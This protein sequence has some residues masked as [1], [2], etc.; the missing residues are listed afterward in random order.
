[1]EA[2]NAVLTKKSGVI[3]YKVF[4][5]R[6]L[7]RLINFFTSR[8]EDLGQENAYLVIEV[9]FEDDSSNKGSDIS[10]LDETKSMKSISFLL[11]GFD[12][13]KKIFM[14]IGEYSRYSVESYDKDWVNA[15]KVEID[16]ILSATQD[17]NYW[18]SSSKWQPIIGSLIG[19]TIGI[20]LYITFFD[21]L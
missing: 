11:G 6:E 8:K 4:T 1:M 13:D 2:K 12:Q 17:Q 21:K 20:L 9:V 19:I 15:N 3:K 7:E 5:R 16:E 10:V 18:L 14:L